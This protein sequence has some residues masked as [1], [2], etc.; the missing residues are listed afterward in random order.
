MTNSIISRLIIMVFLSGISVTAFADD[1]DQI[2]QECEDE[3]A[4]YG[5]EDVDQ[6]QQAIEECIA[7]RSGADMDSADIAPADNN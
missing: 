5:I 7:Y 4:G 3:V 1:A 2:R 6:Q